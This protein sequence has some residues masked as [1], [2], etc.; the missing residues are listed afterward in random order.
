MAA[1]VGSSDRVR[2]PRVLLVPLLGVAA[3]LALVAIAGGRD[4]PRTAFERVAANPEHYRGRTVQVTG[5]VVAHPVHIPPRLLGSFVLR[6]PQGRR[7]LVIPKPDGVL[8]PVGLG[9]RT[10]VRGTVV[11]VEPSA[12][13]LDG[14][15][16]GDVVAI[17]DVA[18]RVDV[19]AL[20][21]ADAV[22]MRA[23]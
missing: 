12:D 9:A 10:A 6:G 13:D 19:V 21:R 3:L 22:T 5:R 1:N 15:R 11:P 8:Q 14:D 16:P 23:G 18:A 20:I 4:Q 2:S 17:G 7:M